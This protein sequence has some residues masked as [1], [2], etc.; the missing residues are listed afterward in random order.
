MNEFLTKALS[1]K[2]LPAIVFNNDENALPVAEAF[3][4]AG[5]NVIEIPFRTTAAADAV[6]AIRKNFPEMYTGAGTLLTETL[7]QKAMDAGAQFGLSA[8]FNPAICDAAKK[9]KF[10]FIPGVMTPSEIELA[11]DLGFTFQK[12]FPINQLGGP[13]YIKAVQEPYE[14]LG[15]KFVPMGGI[16]IS[17][18][19]DYL[20][21]R[22]VIAVG[23]SWV[24]SKEM[25]EQRN[26]KAIEATVKE[27]LAHI[28]Q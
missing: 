22:T 7:M 15:V 21:L 12:V 5:L 3:L 28:K 2:I 10:P 17:N 27:A 25:I 8:G 16:N 9:K 13:A 6:S 14:Q 26:Y 19:K 20:N 1:K 24:A 23:G 11:A 4:K 18:I